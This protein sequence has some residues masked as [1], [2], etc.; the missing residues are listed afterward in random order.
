MKKIIE[1]LT[2]EQFLSPEEFITLVDSGDEALHKQARFVCEKIFGNKIYLRGLIEFTNYCK[3]NCFYCGLRHGNS[4]TERYRLTKEDILECC[5]KG[6][7]SGIRTFVLQGGE[8]VHFTDE[9]MADIIRAIKCRYPDCAVTLSIG[10]REFNS[11]KLLREAGA[12]RYLLRQETSDFEHYSTLHPPE[13]S[14]ISRH[15]CL[16]NVKELGFQTGCGFMVGSPG[17]TFDNIVEDLIFT[18]ELDPAMVGVGPFI[19]HAS[20]PFAKEKAGDL[21]LVL[22]IIAILRLMKPNLLLPAT[23]ALATIDENGYELGI[24]AGANVIMQ[25]ISP[26]SARE[27]YRIYDNKVGAC[28][29]LTQRMQSIGC[30]LVVSRGDYI[31]L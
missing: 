31:E 24:N 2:Q 15:K 28:G 12:D 30:E 27:N 19:P 3:N 17:Q 5:E 29:N 23:T 20:T 22:N 21:R 18:K 7:E 6:Y 11:L 14:L 8:D 1:K 4:N 25:N 10:E 9:I 16:H 13:M 26:L